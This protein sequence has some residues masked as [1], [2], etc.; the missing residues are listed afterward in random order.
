MRGIKEWIQQEGRVVTADFLKVDSF[1]NHRVNPEFIEE[2]GEGIMARFSS[3]EISCVVTAE[4]AGNIIAYEI[5]A[6]HLGVP[7]LY[8]KKG[9]ARTMENSVSRTLDSPTKE[10]PET[11][12]ICRDYLDERQKVLVVDDFLHRGTTANALAEMVL[13]C[14]A[15]LVGFA[16]IIEKV[17][18]KGRQDLERFNVPILAL[19]RIASMDPASGKIE[20]VA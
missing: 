20:F 18:S 19:A 9:Q 11:L 5:A 6:G 7:A 15:T 2:A 3:E 16:F 13:E 10:R 4:A 12:F 17:F 1:L 8:A 14:G